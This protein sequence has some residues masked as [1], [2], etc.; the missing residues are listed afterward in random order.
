MLLGSIWE[1]ATTCSMD[2]KT[3]YMPLFDIAD[4]SLP[5]SIYLENKYN[6][7]SSCNSKCILD[8]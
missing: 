4:F 7:F 5:T 1:S 2:Y 8:C 6:F 3:Y